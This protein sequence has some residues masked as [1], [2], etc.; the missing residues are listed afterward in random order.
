MRLSLVRIRNQ[1]GV[2]PV[3]SHKCAPVMSYGVII[4]VLF[5]GRKREDHEKEGCVC[6]LA[7]FYLVLNLLSRNNIMTCPHGNLWK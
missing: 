7:F 4:R 5:E 3:K 1:N 2:F 6:T